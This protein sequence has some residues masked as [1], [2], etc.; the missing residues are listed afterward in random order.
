MT[1]ARCFD[2]QGLHDF[3]VRLF[4]GSGVPEDSARLVIDHLVDASL[5]GVHSHGIL[6]APEYLDHIDQGL[7][8]ASARPRLVRDDGAVAVFD[9]GR[10]LGQVAA[11]AVCEEVV[12]RA[13]GG[14]G[15]ALVS[16]RRA[17]HFG[18]I[19]AYVEAVAQRGFVAVA[20]CAVPTRHHNV[21]WFG[22]REGRLGTNPIA[23]AFPT[24]GAPVVADFSTSAVPEG[25]VRLLHHEGRP[26]PD[27]VLL[28]ADGQ[29]S[30]DPGV[31]YRQ[32]AGTLRPLGGPQG[33]K[34]SA[35]GLLVEVMGTLLAGEAPDDPG[36]HNSLT[37]VA[38]RCPDGFA[39]GADGLVRYVRSAAPIDPARPPLV[40]GDPEAAARAGATAVPVDA[41]TWERLVARAAAAGLQVP[42]PLGG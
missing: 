37:I 40:P 24:G 31:L 10:C 22:A 28:D 7:V 15:L 38:V 18:R 29:P 30:T 4:V 11:N 41:T 19:G 16:A 6:R 32:P 1:A 5:A 13:G 20:F 34:G 3:L 42:E 2:P 8:A 35:L 9:A 23:Y 17:G 39:D 27:G 26:A 12:P 33:H 25:R 36:R 21:A 14:G